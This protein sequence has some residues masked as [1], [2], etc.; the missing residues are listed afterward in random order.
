MNPAIDLFCQFDSFEPDEVN[1]SY[2]EEYQANGKGVNVSFVLRKMQIANTATG[3]L[4]DSQVILSKKP[5]KIKKLQQ[6][7][8]QSMGLRESIHLYEPIK[9]NIKRLIKDR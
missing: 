4:G 2:Y 5:F 7:L 8:F 9:K 6:I 3:F 1:R